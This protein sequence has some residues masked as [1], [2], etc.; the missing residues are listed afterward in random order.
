MNPEN[1]PDMQAREG[2]GNRIHRDYA[3][4]DTRDRDRAAGSS[5]A[6]RERATDVSDVQEVKPEVEQEDSDVEDVKPNVEPSAKLKPGRNVK[7]NV[8]TVVSESEDTDGEG[9]GSESEV[10]EDLEVLQVCPS[11]IHPYCRPC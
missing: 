9:L 8:E 7:P 3:S 5:P 6:K 1:E 2:S 11:C 4:Q 10:E